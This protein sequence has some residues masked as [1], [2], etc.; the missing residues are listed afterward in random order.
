[1]KIQSDNLEYQGLV[2]SYEKAKSTFETAKA[3]TKEAK[4]SLKA[5]KEENATKTTISKASF[6]YQ[7]AKLKQKAK[8]IAVRIAKLNIKGFEQTATEEEMI[9]TEAPKKIERIKKATTK[10]SID[11]QTD[12][13]EKPESKTGKTKQPT[14]TVDKTSKRGT[15]K[16]LE[17]APE[18]ITEK[19]LS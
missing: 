18:E 9:E 13:V 5:S 2:K 12:A 3:K 11:N 19:S 14:K 7:Q 15:K 17:I 10:K 8:K 16:G 1:M 4:T 6:E